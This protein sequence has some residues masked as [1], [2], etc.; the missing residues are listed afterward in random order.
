MVLLGAAVALVGT[1]CL[2]DLLLTFGVIRR[3]REH[4]ELLSQTGVPDM[5]VTG[6]AAGEPVTAFS[7]LTLSGEL[8]DDASSLRVAGFFSSACS[9]CPERVE[10]FTQYLA[11]HRVAPESVLSVVVTPHDSLPPYAHRLSESGRVCVVRDD[12]EVVKAFR[13]SGFPAFCVLDADGA[14]VAASYD[15]ATLPAPAAAT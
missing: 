7:V 12:S 3:L 13:I 4:T 5:P 15:P 9:A 8:L 2:L 11:G 14:V 1:L 10:P 6:L